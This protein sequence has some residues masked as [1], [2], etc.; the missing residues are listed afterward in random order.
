MNFTV[1][2]VLEDAFEELK[3]NSRALF[4]ALFLPA[5]AI[6]VIEL[7]QL[8]RPE[9][10]G[11]FILSLLRLFLFALFAVS[12]H[13]I[14]LLGQERLKHPFGVYVSKEVLK[15]AG[16][17][18]LLGACVVL[19][20]MLI[21]GFVAFALPRPGGAGALILMLMLIVAGVTMLGVGARICPVFPA[22]AIGDD[23]TL[24]EIVDLTEE[25]WGRLVLLLLLPVLAIS[26]VAFPLISLVESTGSLV[27]GLLVF[28]AICMLEAF[29]V[30]VI[31]CAY[32]ALC[33]EEA[34]GR[35][36]SAA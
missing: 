16:F 15:Y 14:I 17:S 4:R 29:G 23:R 26:V 19:V 34:A 36:G 31:S 2:E 30:A 8:S 24:S 13:R 21:T 12:C 9:A 5:L 25:A 1:S 35:D 22:I 7:I 18:L 27:V 10:G 11:H 28:F 6:S 3:N 20:F 32:R 33:R